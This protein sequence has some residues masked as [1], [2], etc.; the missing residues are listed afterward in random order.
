MKLAASLI[1]RNELGRYLEPCVDHLLEFCDEVVLLDDHSDDGTFRWL[2]SQG[3]RVQPLRHNSEPE[4]FKHEGRARQAL[5]EWTLSREPTHVLAIDADE[6]VDDGPALRR[7]LEQWDE[8]A[9][10]LVMEEIW[11]AAGDGLCVRQ[12]GGWASHAIPAVW[13]VPERIDASWR[14]A[15]RALACGRM[16]RPVD[17]IPLWAYGSLLHFGWANEQERRARYDRYRVA[18]GGRFHA[19]QHLESI[20][21]GCNRVQLQPREWPAGLLPWKD[22]I[23][24]RATRIAA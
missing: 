22:A 3:E 4:F 24:E 20:M 6:F 1:V 5:L 17:S 11:E 13:R 8:A 14:I 16:P 18:D 23:L 7:S 19:S 9:F 12:D 21:W 2:L 15:D 10:G